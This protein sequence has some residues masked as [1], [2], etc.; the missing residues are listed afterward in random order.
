MWVGGGVGVRGRGWVVSW[1][2]GV[3]LGAGE[4]CRRRAPLG[5][6]EVGPRQAAGQRLPGVGEGG[7]GG[8]PGTRG[9]GRGQEGGEQGRV[10]WSWSEGLLARV[11]CEAV[12]RVVAGKSSKLDSVGG[13]GRPER[14]TGCV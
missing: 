3:V 13:Q 12:C 1:G 9:E 8:E 11:S 2:W 6:G 5:R 7:G 10:G 14:V 4:V